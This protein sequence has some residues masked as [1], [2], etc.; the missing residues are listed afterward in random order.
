MILIR[1]LDHETVEYVREFDPDGGDSTVSYPTGTL[2]VTNDPRMALSF[3]SLREAIEFWKQQS[4]RTPW[5]PDGK[6][7]RPLTAY[8]VDFPNMPS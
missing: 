8:T 6:A 1:I 2:I 5:R 4:L 3:C 7:N